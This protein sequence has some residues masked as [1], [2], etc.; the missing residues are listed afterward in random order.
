MTDDNR[1]LRARP[2]WS[3]LREHIVSFSANL[4]DLETQDCSK[5]MK[6][7]AVSALYS[8]QFSNCFR[9]NTCYGDIATHEHLMEFH[10]S[11]GG[12]W[13]LLPKWSTFLFKMKSI[14][15]SCTSAKH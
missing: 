10:L 12:T 13:L 6:T 3:L 4:A 8:H 2:V 11:Q 9:Q 15:R 1:E 5:M 14:I 7:A